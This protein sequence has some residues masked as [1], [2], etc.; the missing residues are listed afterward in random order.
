MCHAQP[1]GHARQ[2]LDL[3]AIVMVTADERP[4]ECT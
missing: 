1:K 2:L 4:P 3:L